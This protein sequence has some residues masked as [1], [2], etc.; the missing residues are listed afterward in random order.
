MYA[1]IIGICF[2]AALLVKDRGVAEKE[3][4]AGAGDNVGTVE[5]RGR[6]DVVAEK[7]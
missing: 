5:R 1:P 3:K 4:L 2:I 6:K 7:T